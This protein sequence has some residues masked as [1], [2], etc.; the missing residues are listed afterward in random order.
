MMIGFLSTI[1]FFLIA[2]AANCAFPYYAENKLREIPNGYYESIG[3]F[4]AW[5]K[6]AFIFNEDT[7]KWDLAPDASRRRGKDQRGRRRGGSGLK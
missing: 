1:V 5:E 6:E 4:C 2:E 7:G 3:C